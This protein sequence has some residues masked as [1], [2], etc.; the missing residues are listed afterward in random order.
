[1]APRLIP[2]TYAALTLLGNGS[3]GP[4]FPNMGTHGVDR[5][6]SNPHLE[7]QAP[8]PLPPQQAP[9]SR[10]L[11]KQ[12]PRVPH[13]RE[14]TPVERPRGTIS[15]RRKRFPKPGE[16]IDSPENRSLP[17]PRLRRASSSGSQDSSIDAPAR[18]RGTKK[19]A[20]ARTSRSPRSLPFPPPAGS[21]PANS[22][23]APAGPRRWRRTERSR[24]RRPTTETTTTP[25]TPTK[26]RVVA[27]AATARPAVDGTTAERTV[28]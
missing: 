24:V 12:V 28:R 16:R 10:L 6:V 18:R 23:P 7:E 21:T 26:Q 2:R 27:R 14:A 19:A 4:P 13:L 15:S 20:R 3:S 25:K 11:C 17:E 22:T 8:P 9:R 1:M 5:E